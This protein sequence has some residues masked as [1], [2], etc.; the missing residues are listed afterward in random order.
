MAAR[1]T[2]KLLGRGCRGAAGGDLLLLQLLLLEGRKV[3]YRREGLGRATAIG[4]GLLGLRIPRCGR[5]RI[6]GVHRKRGARGAPAGS[7]A[8]ALVGSGG[9]A[10]VVIRS[11]DAA[12]SRSCGRGRGGDSIIGR[13]GRQPLLRQQRLLCLPL[14][15]RLLSRQTVSNVILERAVIRFAV[16]KHASH[17]VGARACCDEIAALACLEA[18]R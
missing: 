14:R 9:N 6:G 2:H 10:I 17:L 18:F 4:R 13:R 8:V 1:G 7:L 16:G 15:D 3:A 11:L 12:R 5:R